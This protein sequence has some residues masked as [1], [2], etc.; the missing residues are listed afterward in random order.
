MPKKATSNPSTPFQRYHAVHGD[1]LRAKKRAD[2]NALS[3]EE[4]EQEKA[5]RRNHYATNRERIKQE[6]KA[7]REAN[8]AEERAKAKEYRLTHQEQARKTQAKADTKRRAKHL[9]QMRQRRIKM[10]KEAYNA[11]QRA[12][13]RANPGAVRARRARRKARIRNL[14][15]TWTKAEYTFMMQYWHFSCAI[16][17]NE[18]GFMWSIVG[19]HWV[20][21]A[22]PDC[23]G[24]I[25]ENMLPLCNGN[26]GCNTFKQDRDPH[27][28]LLERFGPR[29]AAQMEKAIAAYF[30]AVR[31]AFPLTLENAL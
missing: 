12:T 24:T 25:A 14:P 7:K 2:Y 5:K 8:L 17:G 16:C 13:E 3:P 10:G 31:I 9:E 21:L 20:P 23:P 6:R 30:L 1:R 29:K 19:D 26:G 27:T 15:N 22:S 28:W 11:E 18:E 4:R